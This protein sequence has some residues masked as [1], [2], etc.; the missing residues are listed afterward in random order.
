MDAHQKAFSKGW[1]E[2]TDDSLL[3]EKIGIPVKVILG[4]EDNIKITTP[5]DI[6]LARFLM[7]RE[8]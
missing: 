4:S 8:E 5:H 7:G 6:I 1:D 2:I 3:I